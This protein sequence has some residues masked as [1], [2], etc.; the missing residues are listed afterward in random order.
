MESKKLIEILKK[1]IEAKVYMVLEGDLYNI[2]E[3]DVEILEQGKFDFSASPNLSKY[4]QKPE[5]YDNQWVSL[6]WGKEASGLEPLEKRT[7][8]TIG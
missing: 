4:T 6:K 8:I 2:N 7:I 5:T 1:N 3:G